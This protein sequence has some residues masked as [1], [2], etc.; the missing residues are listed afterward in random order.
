MKTNIFELWPVPILKGNIG[1]DK[2]IVNFCDN[3]EYKK[4]SVGYT[5]KNM[6]VL[7]SLKDVK[8][9]IKNELHL[10]L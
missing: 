9:S 4:S 8:D 10:Y 3:I 7:D 2:T 6:K 5:S 1:S